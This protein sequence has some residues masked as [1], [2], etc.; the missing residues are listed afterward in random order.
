MPPP[1]GKGRWCVAPEG[2]RKPVSDRAN[3]I[4]K[5]IRK[6]AEDFFRKELT[7]GVLR[8]IMGSVKI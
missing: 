2:I 6:K 1:Y 3:Q 4:V 5:S 8:A 7:K